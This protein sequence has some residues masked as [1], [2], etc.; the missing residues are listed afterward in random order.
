[1]N[2]KTTQHWSTPIY[3][4]N[5]N[6]PVFVQSLIDFSVELSATFPTKN[7]PD[8]DGAAK[9]FDY[10]R[11]VNPNPLI[12]RL[13]DT[14]RQHV[15]IYLSDLPDTYK[16][17]TK[18]ALQL[19]VLRKGEVTGY[20]GHDYSFLTGIVYLSPQNTGLILHDPRVNAGR[21]YPYQFRSWFS[22]VVIV[23]E[24]GDIVLFPSFVFHSTMVHNADEPRYVLPFNVIA[25]QK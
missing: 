20:H 9:L 25:V 4:D 3:Q 16:L 14:I 5:F 15:D 17:N 7:D 23:P 8:F 22:D 2:D 1:M 6:D 10:L 18:T 12:V 11:F 13:D 19:C 24:P 21:A